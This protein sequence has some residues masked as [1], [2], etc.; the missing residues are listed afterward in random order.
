[1]IQEGRADMIIPVINKQTIN[2]NYFDAQFV[3]H[4]IFKANMSSS[5]DSAVQTQVK[6]V[7][8]IIT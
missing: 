8:K 3:V 7:I 2:C 5:L 4:V 1:M 6:V